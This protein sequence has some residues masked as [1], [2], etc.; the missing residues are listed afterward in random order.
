MDK[1]LTHDDVRR[2]LRELEEITER[3]RQLHGRLQAEL[4]EQQEQLSEL[5]D[6]ILAEGRGFE[7]RDTDKELVL[8]CI[9]F[10]LASTILVEAGQQ[11]GNVDQLRREIGEI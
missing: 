1:P 11:S 7:L 8:S 3:Y 6:W 5:L 4:F 2:S 10:A 9:Q